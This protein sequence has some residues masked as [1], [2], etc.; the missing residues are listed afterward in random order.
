MREFLRSSLDGD[1]EIQ[2]CNGGAVVFW[3]NTAGGRCSARLLFSQDSDEPVKPQEMPLFVLT[4][5]RDEMV[6]FARVVERKEKSWEHWQ[7]RLK[8][9]KRR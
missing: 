9:R 4:K 5:L 3:A 8:R 6:H 2:E 7:D 1:V